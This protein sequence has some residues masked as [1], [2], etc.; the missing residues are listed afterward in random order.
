MGNLSIRGF[1]QGLGDYK[2]VLDSIK[3][4]I[5]EEYCDSLKRYFYTGPEATM[6]ANMHH[7]GYIL[8]NLGRTAGA[9]ASVGLTTCS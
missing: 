2:P 5:T 3:T 6:S 9:F 4:N 7:V 8:H 1:W